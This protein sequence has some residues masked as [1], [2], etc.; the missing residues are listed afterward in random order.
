MHPLGVSGSLAA[1][2]RV[3]ARAQPYEEVLAE[4]LEESVRQ[5][6]VAVGDWAQGRVVRR[7]PRE[8]RWPCW[9]GGRGATA[10]QGL[11]PDLTRLCAVSSERVTR[12]CR[13]YDA[14]PRC[15]RGGHDGDMASTHDHPA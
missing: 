5:A 9:R 8:R 14:V 12:A 15:R 6:H 4:L 11:A 7:A 1:R 3:A 2:R 10:Q 13:A